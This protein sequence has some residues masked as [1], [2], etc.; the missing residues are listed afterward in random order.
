MNSI[1]D[2]LTA[3]PKLLSRAQPAPPCTLVIFGAG[4]DLTK[5]L[6]MPSLYNMTV[7]GLFDDEF[8]VVG[9]DL[10]DS[11]DDAFRKAQSETMQGFVTNKGG[12]FHTDHIDQKAWGWLSERLHYQQGDFGKDETFAALKQKLA[13][14]HAKTQH[15]NCVFYLAVADRFFGPSST[16]SPRPAC[17]IR[18]TRPSAAWSWRSRSATT[19]NRPRT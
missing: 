7:A 14:I 2:T 16:S 6:L 11:N 15:A 5:R 12:E 9:V 17:S 1:S 3:D 4:G 19:C 8:G 18:R 10:A 13:D